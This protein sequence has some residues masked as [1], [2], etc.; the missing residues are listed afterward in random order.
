VDQFKPNFNTV[1]GIQ[2][3]VHRDKRGLFLEGHRDAEGWPKFVQDNISISRKGV[4]R[5][6]HYQID[7][8]A[9]GKL[10]RVLKGE[11]LDA[12]LDLRTGQL[13]KMII[14]DASHDAVYIPPG[15]AHGFQALCEDTIVYYKCTE[16]YS[17][18]HERGF[19]PVDFEWPI[20]DMIISDKDKSL[21]RYT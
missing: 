1:T 4:V 21:P 16:F 7:P 20:A 14:S 5:G 11:I 8:K 13:H 2:S 18:E 12:M 6:M 3:F 17:P 9:Q 19:S 15:Y 10:V